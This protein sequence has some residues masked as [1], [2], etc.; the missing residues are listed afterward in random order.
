MKKFPNVFLNLEEKNKFPTY[1]NPELDG[2]YNDICVETINLAVRKTVTTL[3]QFIEKDYLILQHDIIIS[4]IMKQFNYSYEKLLLHSVFTQRSILICHYYINKKIP[5]LNKEGNLVP[6]SSIKDFLNDKLFDN[7][8]SELNSESYFNKF[9]LF[10]EDFLSKEDS[11]FTISKQYTHISNNLDDKLNIE[12]NEKSEFIINKDNIIKL[13]RKENEVAED[14]Y[15]KIIFGNKNDEYAL[16]RKDKG[17]LKERISL[18]VKDEF[19]L[20]QQLSNKSFI[21]SITNIYICLK[22]L[23]TVL[24]DLE[25]MLEKFNI[26]Y[27]NTSKNKIKINYEDEVLDMYEYYNR[28]KFIQEFINQSGRTSNQDLFDKKLNTPEWKSIIPYIHQYEIYDQEAMRKKIKKIHDMINLATSFVS[29]GHEAEEGFFRTLSTSYYMTHYF[30]LKDESDKQAKRFATAPNIKVAQQVWGLLENQVLE[31]GLRL[32]LPSIKYRET[33][34]F[35]KMKAP[36]TYEELKIMFTECASQEGF[37]DYMKDVY[38]GENKRKYLD[39]LN[40]SH[41]SE[42]SQINQ[43]STSKENSLNY[44]NFNDKNKIISNSNKRMKEDYTKKHLILKEIEDTS[45]SKYVKIKLLHN[46]EIIIPQF[47]KSNSGIFSCYNTKPEANYTRDTLIIHIHGGGF[48]AMSSTSHENYLRN[49]VKK[50]DVPLISIDYRLA[51]ENPYP[52]AIDDVYQAYCFILNY[53]EEHLMI[54]LNNIILVGDSA[55]GNLCCGLVNLLILK[56]MRTPNLLL[57]A[58]PAMR[59]DADVFSP[60]KLICLK[61]YI[62]S[63]HFLLLVREAYLGSRS[64]EIQKDDFFAS[65]I[66]TPNHVR[67]KV[68]IFNLFLLICRY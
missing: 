44:S 55:G 13:G 36:I 8:N 43:L 15:N 25:K 27:K 38:S 57:L 10:E 40:N 9:I 58:Y 64:E 24:N 49:W 42:V 54:N 5:T 7:L 47:D 37:K 66:Y 12:S 50:L 56:N 60:S 11:D 26:N 3:Q 59:I 19:H 53:A 18:L 32:T 52:D 46:S 67:Y 68:I 34:Y 39:R 29:K 21:P 41:Y 62:L 28:L 63:I 31:S 17:E 1:D 2:D 16:S 20:I 61:D 51:P 35:R 23:M 45:L 4:K 22:Y 65:P 14:I 33:L 30:F 48:V 6:Y